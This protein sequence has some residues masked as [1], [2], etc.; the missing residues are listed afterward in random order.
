MREKKYTKQYVYFI[1][2]KPKH[3]LV[4]FFKSPVIYFLFFKLQVLIICNTRERP[5]PS[6][7]PIYHA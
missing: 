6:M 3:N 2:G 4:V 1:L 7:W 5:T